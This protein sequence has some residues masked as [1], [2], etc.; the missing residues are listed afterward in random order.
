MSHILVVDNFDSFTYNLVQ[1]LGICGAKTT[2]IRNNELDE[3]YYKS[4]QLD[5]ILLSP[6]PCSPAQSGACLDVISDALADKL[7]GKPVFG[8]CLG[9]QTIGH[10]S[11]AIVTQ[12][13][14]PRHGK[15]SQIL[16]DNLGVFKD[17]PNPMTAVRYHSLS[18]KHGTL[19]NDFIISAT[20]QDDGE[21]MGVRHKYLPI[22]GVQFHPESILTIGGLQLIQNFLDLIVN[23]SSK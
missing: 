1:Y 15:T 7:N 11:G 3:S 13:N 14:K 5:A 10:Q 2:V 9:H 19:S 4:S 16:H 6:G 22:E 8:V 20:S 18:I 23:P 21:I 12:A 17:I